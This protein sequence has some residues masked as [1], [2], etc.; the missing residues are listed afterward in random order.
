MGTRPMEPRRPQEIDGPQL[1]AHLSPLTRPLADSP[2]DA[3]LAEAT[4]AFQVNYIRRQIEAC[5]GNMTLAA[6]RLGLDRANLY[7]KMKQLDAT[8][9]E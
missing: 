2:L 1:A 5:G 3:P 6:E 4:A 7:R 8:G 9:M